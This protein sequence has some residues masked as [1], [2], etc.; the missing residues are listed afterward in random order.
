MEQVSEVWTE[1][2]I[3]EVAKEFGE[4][5]EI[6]DERRKCLVVVKKIGNTSNAYPRMFNAIKKNPL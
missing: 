5:L 3:R 4:E 6:E 1:D 2:I